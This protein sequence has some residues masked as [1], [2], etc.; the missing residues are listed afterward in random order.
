MKLL[1]LAAA[2]PLLLAVSAKIDFYTYMDAICRGIGYTLADLA[3]AENPRLCGDIQLKAIKGGA[4]PYRAEVH[5]KKDAETAC[6][7][8]PATPNGEGFLLKPGAD[9]AELG[10]G[11]V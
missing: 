4:D 11:D 3:A 8:G 7:H 1:T 10:G 6:Q 5:G 9:C 2:L